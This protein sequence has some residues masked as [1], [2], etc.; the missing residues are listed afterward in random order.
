MKTT[1]G[2]SFEGDQ[3]FRLEQK[4]LFIKRTTS[5]DGG[6]L[7]FYKADF[8]Q[9]LLNWKLL[10]EIELWNERGFVETV[11]FSAAPQD[12]VNLLSERKKWSEWLTHWK[13]AA[14]VNGVP[15]LRTGAK[16]AGEVWCAVC[17]G[18]VVQGQKACEI[19]GAE[20]NVKAA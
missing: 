16:K 18:V 1:L 7:S 17:M 9:M 15:K 13:P 6:M 14:S 20:L 10:R 11:G 4:G 2:N 5:N 8:Q 12:S 3:L 19:C